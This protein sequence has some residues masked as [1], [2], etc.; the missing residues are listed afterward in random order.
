MSFM[1]IMIIVF[2]LW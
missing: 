1:F 2:N